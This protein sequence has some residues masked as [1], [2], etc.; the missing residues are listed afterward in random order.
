MRA[1]N[2]KP[3][4]GWQVDTSFAAPPCDT[5]RCCHFRPKVKSRSTERRAVVTGYTRRRPRV[6][7]EKWLH[8]LKRQPSVY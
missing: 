4:Y 3:E 7:L 5:P 2:E 8:A 6:A 1:A